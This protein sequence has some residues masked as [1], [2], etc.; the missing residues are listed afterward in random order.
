MAPRIFPPFA[1]TRVANGPAVYAGSGDIVSGAAGWWGLRAYSNATIGSNAVRLRRDSDNAESD[2]VTIT[3]G[4]LDTASITTFAGAA[5]LFVTKLYDQSGNGNDASQ[6]TASQQP[7]FTLSGLGA[8]PIMTFASASNQFLS[9]AVGFFVGFLVPATIFTVFNPSSVASGTH[10]LFGAGSGT[11]QIEYRS[12]G[13]SAMQILSQGAAG[14]VVGA[15]PVSNGTWY[16]GAANCDGS[17]NTNI[18]TIYLNGSNDGS[19]STGL[20]YDNTPTFGLGA[21]VSVADYWNGSATEWGAW[22][23][24]LSGPQNN[25]LNSNAHTFWGF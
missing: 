23:A 6:G 14:I 2:F 12:N 3:N 4:L 24:I 8:L 19:V 21:A 9:I 7:S 15:T 25:S 22:N 11:G 16:T 5:N 17:A 1:S 20:N 18:T 13:G 10:A